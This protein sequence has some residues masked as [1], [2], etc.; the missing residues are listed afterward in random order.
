MSRQFLA[1]SFLSALYY[2]LRSV[3]IF[4]KLR[5]FAGTG[6]WTFV[7][8]RVDRQYGCVHLCNLSAI[9]F[10]FS[11]PCPII[12]HR[13]G[14]AS[15]KTAV[16]PGEWILHTG[17]LLPI[18][19]TDSPLLGRNPPNIFMNC[20]LFGCQIPLSFLLCPW[21]FIQIFLHIV[22]VRYHIGILEL[23]CLSSSDVTVDCC[24]RL[25]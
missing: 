4:P 13:R 7:D 18:P 10:L 23:H 9:K 17:T 20:D 5:I 3:L 16:K 21:S 12:V 14:I 1:L 22:P 19:S 11:D 8:F 6:T 25:P 15:R 24:F 2:K